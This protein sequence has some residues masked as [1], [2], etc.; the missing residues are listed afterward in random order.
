[1]DIAEQALRS[2]LVKDSVGE[3]CQKL[4][5]D[6]LDEFSVNG[7]SKYLTGVQDL[8]RP[9]RNT[10]TV[11]FE[12]IEAY[13]QQLA[14]T[15]LEEYYRVYPF[16]CRAVRNYAKDW[17]QIPS[18]KEFYLSLID[19]PTKLKVREMTTVKIGSLLRITGQVVRTHPVHPELVSG[20]FM[21]LDCRTVIKDVEQQF[22]YTQPTICRNPVCANRSRFMLDV[23]HSRF[24]DF[25]KVR[26]QET[27]AE[28]PRGSIPRSVE[29]ILRAEA[30]ETA[31]AGDR[32]DFTGT[33]I[34][35]PDVG[36]MS[37]PGAQAET[38]AKVNRGNEGYETEGVRGLKTLGVRDLT[39]RLAFLACTVTPSNSKFGGQSFRE[40]GMTAESIKKRM[41]DEEWQTV[42]DMSQDKNLYQN[43]CS[44]LFPTIHGND[45]IKRGILLM[46]FGGVPKVTL[47]RTNLRGDINIC[48][49][50]DPSTAKS[51]FLKQVE[52]FSPR[53][54]YTSGKASSAAG[55]TAAVVR[56]EESHEFVIEAGALM[57]ADNGVCC[58]DEFDK[59]DPHDQVAIHEAMEQQTISITKAGV[60]ATLNARTSILAAANPVGGRYD[61]SK[62]LKHNINMSAPIM[63]RF[64][65][66]FILVDECNEVTDYA[67]ARR[68]VDLH[69]RAD[70]SV[71]RFYSVEDICRYIMFARQFK[72]KIS[73]EARDFMV[74]EY[75]RLRQRDSSGA[76]SSSWRIT[77]RQL[78]SMIRLS[79]AMSRMH[80]QD[81]VR[82]GHVKEAFRLLNKSIIRVEQP[83]IEL[84]DDVVAPE[85][86]EV[87]ENTAP[88]QS[89]DACEDSK[90]S[91]LKQPE[92]VAV[93]G[94]P[95]LRLSYEDYK[96]MA[97]LIVLHMRKQE[98]EAG[99]DESGLRK[100]EVIGW[101]LTEIQDE[102]HSEEQLIEKRTVVEKVID[103]LVH[104]D[105]VLI[106]LTQT[107][108]KPRS[109]QEDD[110]HKEA[111]PILVVHPNYIIDS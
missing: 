106:Q 60:R 89:P 34:V 63:S 28:L 111:D 57:L 23:N 93:P 1:M 102:L 45:E 50:G 67:I 66:F 8:I 41:S 61:R 65:L 85:Q 87:D 75:K 33:L 39:Y 76:G 32:C 92:P 58:I 26:I 2:N 49:V 36:S 100:S 98:E 78:E 47:E 84:E 51:Q 79:E 53:A 69:S 74:E 48:I 103:R 110:M 20:T 21:C 109:G 6:F 24:V 13:N 55:L 5:Q 104:H 46:L 64:D 25:Q 35:V 72:P 99:E 95:A 105:H 7:E 27:Q 29:V 30:V 10:L 68:I 43:L 17:G 22:K 73:A 3:R 37:M 12:D 80:C 101:Y 97:N 19:V 90:G 44:S 70:E 108:L 14:T 4:F 40:E 16:L 31:Q 86:M 11:S 62:S 71:D 42:Y 38:S 82:P 56:D 94:K 52:E 88:D 83:D 77:V 9:E 81:E 18:G 15:I 107:G 54:V 91:P 96:H 59:M